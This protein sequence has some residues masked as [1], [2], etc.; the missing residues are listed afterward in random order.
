[1]RP[2]M[3][4]V[5]ACPNNRHYS[6][7]LRWKH[8]YLKS[9]SKRPVTWWVSSFINLFL[10]KDSLVLHLNV[11]AETKRD[12]RGFWALRSSKRRGTSSKCW[13]WRFIRLC[14]GFCHWNPSE[15]GKAEVKRCMKTTKRCHI[16]LKLLGLFFFFF[17]KCR[18]FL[19]RFVPCVWW[20]SKSWRT[21]CPKTWP[22]W[23]F[24]L[25]NY[26]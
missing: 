17:F 4:P 1:M 7:I 25:I 26:I 19:V 11:S 15:F 23:M 20:W 5:C 10:S 8:T 22:R 2:C 12:L 3:L 18:K 21:C 6:V 13:R 14:T 24:Y 16:H 9:C